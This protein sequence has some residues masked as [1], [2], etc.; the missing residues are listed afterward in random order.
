MYTHTQTT[1]TSVYRLSHC[2]NSP[3]MVGGWTGFWTVNDDE[4]EGDQETL[5]IGKSAE[6]HIAFELIHFLRPS[7]HHTFFTVPMCLLLTWCQQKSI[8]HTRVQVAFLHFTFVGIV[9][10]HKYATEGFAMSLNILLE[11]WSRRASFC[12]SVALEVDSTFG[13]YF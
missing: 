7:S 11:A 13:S 12:L 3:L 1:H 9:Q 8:S 2:V 4:R 10:D 6:L 5:A